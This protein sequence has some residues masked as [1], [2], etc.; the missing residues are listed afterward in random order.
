S[1]ELYWVHGNHLGVP[2]V[3]TNAQGQVVTPANDFLRPGFPGQSEVLADLYY[4]RARDYDPVLG[5]YIQADPIGL[6]EDVNP[7]VYAGSDPVNM[8]DPLGLMT[9]WEYYTGLPDRYRTNTMNAIAGWFDG[10]TLGATWY[11]REWIGSNRG[12]SDCH[13]FYSYGGYAGLISLGGA[14]RT[15]FKKGAERSGL[16]DLTKREVRRIQR[17]VDRAGRP[18]DVVGSAA[19]GGRRNPRSRLP[20]GKGPGTKS[21]IDYIT[22]P[23]HFPNFRGRMGRLPEIDPR[24][25]INPGAHNPFQGSVIRFEPGV[26]PKFNPGQ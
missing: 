9:R 7:Y 1:Q 13:T 17:E 6:A 5:R 4:N 10:M 15:F 14:V 3:T 18:L 2:V 19:R 21:D 8:I 23:Q 16:G 25:G 24:T 11:V 20:F 26:S 12:I 22:N